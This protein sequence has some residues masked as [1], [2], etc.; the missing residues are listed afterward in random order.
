MGTKFLEVICDDNGIGNS[1]ECCGDNASHLG[2]INV[3]YYEAFS[4][5]YDADHS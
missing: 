1:G 4:C 3:F 5:K 2:R